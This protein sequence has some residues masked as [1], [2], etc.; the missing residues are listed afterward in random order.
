MLTVNIPIPPPPL[1]PCKCV[2][3]CLRVKQITGECDLSCWSTWSGLVTG[4]LR[5]HLVRVVSCSIF[6]HQLREGEAWADVVSTTTLKLQGK[7][8]NSRSCIYRSHIHFTYACRSE[9]VDD[10]SCF[11][12]HYLV[13]LEV[14]MEAR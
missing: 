6:F 10:V 8:Y 2:C 14:S 7:H 9:G 1:Y 13:P 3:L 4:Q 12:A 11:T 5:S